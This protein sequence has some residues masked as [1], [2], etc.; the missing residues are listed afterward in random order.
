MPKSLIF[1]FY[2]GLQK[3]CFH[4]CSAAAAA[5]ASLFPL[6]ESLENA[7]T[8]FPS[9]RSRRVLVRKTEEFGPFRGC[10]P[11]SPMT[12]GGVHRFGWAHLPFLNGNNW[13]NHLPIHELPEK[14]VAQDKIVLL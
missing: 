13:H 14:E 3:W 1:Y 11:F 6:L 7:G 2:S 10:P 5:G 9:A 8:Q 4:R 12:G